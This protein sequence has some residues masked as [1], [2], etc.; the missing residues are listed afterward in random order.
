LSKVFTQVSSNSDENPLHFMFSMLDLYLPFFAQ[1]QGLH[2]NQ[3][4]LF[5][6][7]GINGHF[8]CK[9]T[10]ASLLLYLV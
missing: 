1:N 2:D 3:N 10:E 5:E 6:N 9:T 4:L 8:K 7:V